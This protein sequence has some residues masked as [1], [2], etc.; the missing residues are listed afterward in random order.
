MALNQ[1][2]RSDGRASGPAGDFENWKFLSY[3]RQWPILLKNSLRVFGGKS[4]RFRKPEISLIQG[5]SRS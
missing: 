3:D 1:S 4:W 5:N 2:M